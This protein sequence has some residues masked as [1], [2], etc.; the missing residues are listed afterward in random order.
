MLAIKA[1]VMAS[2]PRIGTKSRATIVVPTKRDAK[3][4]QPAISLGIRSDLKNRK[5][6]PAL[7]NEAK[8]ATF[9]L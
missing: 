2:W 7:A 5:K 6:K 8:K 4:P 3:T 1:T 9:N